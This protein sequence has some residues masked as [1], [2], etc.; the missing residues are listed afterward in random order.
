MGEFTY[1]IALCDLFIVLMTFAIVW[2]LSYDEQA[3]I[4]YY[5]FC[6]IYFFFSS[7]AVPIHNS[8]PDISTAMHVG[9]FV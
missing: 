2:I 4:C 3:C 9:K 8:Q 5:D 6:L 7:L 1:S